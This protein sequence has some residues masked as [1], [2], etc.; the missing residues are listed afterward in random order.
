MI[1]ALAKLGYEIL[2]IT[3]VK[4]KQVLNEEEIRGANM[5]IRETLKATTLG[6]LMIER[7]VGSGFD[8]IIISFHR[9]YSSYSNLV[10]LLRNTEFLDMDR[11]ASFL[12]NLRDDVYFI[13]LTFSFVA[14]ELSSVRGKKE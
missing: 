2:A 8:G 12:V 14:H 10:E 4:L 3:L 5:L 7:G 13:P 6:V 11:V 9:S 1:P